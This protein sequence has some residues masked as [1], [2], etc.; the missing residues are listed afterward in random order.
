MKWQEARVIYP[1]RWL[2][3]EALETHTESDRKV[4]LDEIAVLD[5]CDDG[6]KVM[7]LYQS[8]RQKLR[9]R[10]ILFVHSTNAEPNLYDLTDQGRFYHVPRPAPRV[11]RI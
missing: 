9:G 8:W 10:E 2:V 4:K 5:I 3:I 11:E 6:G 1:D 7:R